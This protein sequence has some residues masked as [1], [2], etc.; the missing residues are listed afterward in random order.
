MMK[1]MYRFFYH[2]RKIKERYIKHQKEVLLIIISFLIILLS[3]GLG[4]IT[5]R[6]FST[7]PIIIEK[8]SE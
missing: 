8:C 3:F 2:L 6:D 5:A 1:I 4:Y 7:T